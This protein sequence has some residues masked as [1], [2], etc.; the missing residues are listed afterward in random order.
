MYVL[1]EH[2]QLGIGK[3]LFNSMTR[4]LESNGCSS[5]ML[6]VL[7]DNPALAFYTRQGGRQIGQKNIVIGTNDLIE[8]AMGW[9]FAADTI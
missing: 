9:N 2:Q 8:F 1:Q 7:R 4:H 6:W 5:M 3:L